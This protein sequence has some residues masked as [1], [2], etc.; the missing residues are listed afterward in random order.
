L[1]LVLCFVNSRSELSESMVGKLLE[2]CGV[3]GKSRQKQ[4]DAREFLV[5]KSVRKI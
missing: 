1:E 4:H 3:K 5:T 2:Q